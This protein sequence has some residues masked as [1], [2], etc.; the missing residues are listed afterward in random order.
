MELAVGT[1]IRYTSAAGT[2]VATVRNIRVGPTAAPDFLNT[3][4]TLDIPVQEGVK[5]ATAVQ[6]PADNDS[7]LAFRVEVV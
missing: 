2:R 3:W 5:F 1:Q 4:M 6:L 7:L